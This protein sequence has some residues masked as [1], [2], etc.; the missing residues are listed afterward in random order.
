MTNTKD[1]YTIQSIA[2]GLGF[3]DCVHIGHRKVFDILKYKSKEYN[4]LPTVVTFRDNP[5]LS[6]LP[7]Y[8]YFDRERL[9]KECGIDNIYA[10]EFEKIKDMTAIDFLNDCISK[11]GIKIL[12]CG[13]DFRFGNG[14]K[15]DIHLLQEFATLHNI[16]SVIVD[17]VNA[18]NQRVS[19]THIR[20]LL[21]KGNVV[22]ANLLLGS[23]YFINGIV[24]HGKGIGK[25]IAPTINM[26]PDI[27]K[28]SIGQGVY[29]TH[30]LV[31]DKW[32]RSVTNVG[33]QPTVDCKVSY[34]ETH[35]INY[36]GNLYGQQCLIKFERKLRDIIKFDSIE[37]LK[38]Q[39]EI[40]KNW[41]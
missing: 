21:N 11:M 28:H 27:K 26:I 25:T 19:T 17:T 30:T 40:D 2:L 13:N 33:F 38:S 6:S 22:Q 36:S 31:D 39:I 18:D 37:D 12:V 9:I 8:N 24:V 1:K 20:E 7:I 34:I 23:P 3:F 10:L 5:K 41:T 29:G 16:D 35:I 32:Y 15:G 14:A 4:V